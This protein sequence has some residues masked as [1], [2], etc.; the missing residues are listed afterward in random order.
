MLLLIEEIIVTNA[1]REL[2][3]LMKIQSRYYCRCSYRDTI[4]DRDRDTVIDREQ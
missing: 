2:L 1:D 4:T 3:L